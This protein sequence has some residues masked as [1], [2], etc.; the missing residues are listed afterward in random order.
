MRAGWGWRAGKGR[1]G[2][3]RSRRC[4]E[5]TPGPLPSRPGVPAEQGRRELACGAGP[6]L[7]VSLRK[8]P[9]GCLSSGSFCH[10]PSGSLLP[11]TRAVAEARRP[12]AAPSRCRQSELPRPGPAQPSPMLQRRPSCSRCWALGQGCRGRAKLLFIQIECVRAY[13]HF[14]IWPAQGKPLLA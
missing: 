1:R 13:T 9:P 5:T 7:A 14:S 4:R 2:A 8:S 6:A 3:G 10:L 12:P 11:P